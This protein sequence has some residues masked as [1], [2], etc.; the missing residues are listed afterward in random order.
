MKRAAMG[1]LLKPVAKGRQGGTDR[2]LSLS[3]RH[4]AQQAGGNREHDIADH[5]ASESPERADDLGTVTGTGTRIGTSPGAGASVDISGDRASRV[6]RGAEPSAEMAGG[7]RGDPARGN[8]SRNTGDMYGHDDRGET[9]YGAAG[10]GTA[11]GEE[12]LAHGPEGGPLSGSGDHAA[13]GLGSTNPQPADP[14]HAS[15]ARSDLGE[16]G[17]G[18]TADTAG[19]GGVSD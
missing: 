16:A 5:D 15:V 7:G 1:S 4:N 11:A 8:R 10:T 14:T 17:G 3:G 19:L 12:R 2:A 13:A 6:S 9:P 18:D